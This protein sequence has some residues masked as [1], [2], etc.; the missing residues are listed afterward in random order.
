MVS[1]RA[2]SDG[3]GCWIET[4][5]AGFVGAVE[6]ALAACV[7][8]ACLMGVGVGGAAFVVASLEPIMYPTAA[9]STIAANAET[10]IRLR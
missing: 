9:S 4:E 2:D 6:S 1:T 10:T 5:S 8:G 7:G 3:S